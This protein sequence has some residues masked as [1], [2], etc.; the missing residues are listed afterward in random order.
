MNALLG[1]KLHQCVATSVLRATAGLRR[2]YGSAT[3]FRFNPVDFTQDYLA[4]ILRSKKIL[5][6][7]RATTYKLHGKYVC[8]GNFHN[9]YYQSDKLYDIKK[10][11]N[12]FYGFISVYI[13]KGQ[14]SKSNVL[15]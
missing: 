5:M 4:E 6:L 14:R 13:K 3:K 1:A 15:I 11:L 7:A 8:F 9:R 12:Y 2:C 10:M